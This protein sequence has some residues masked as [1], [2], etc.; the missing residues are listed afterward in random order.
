MA[1]AVLYKCLEALKI[2]ATLVVF[3]GLVLR[4]ASTMNDHPTLHATSSHFRSSTLDCKAAP[5]EPSPTVR[6]LLRPPIA[7][8][9]C[10]PPVGQPESSC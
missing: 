6:S 9:H 1:L 7:M 5:S 10:V 2:S 4:Q 3:Q 8:L